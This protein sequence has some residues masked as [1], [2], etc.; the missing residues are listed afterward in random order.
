MRTKPEHLFPGGPGPARSFCSYFST[1]PHTHTPSEGCVSGFH[2][3]YNVLTIVLKP[4]VFSLFIMVLNIKT[5]QNY[6]G[7]FDTA[8]PKVLEI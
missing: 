7:C 5:I 1:P 3:D 6:F 4:S 2:V 8:S